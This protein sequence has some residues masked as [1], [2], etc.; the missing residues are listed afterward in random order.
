MSRSYPPTTAQLA[1][2]LTKAFARTPDGVIVYEA[3][4]DAAGQITDFTIVD[5]NPAGQITAGLPETIFFRGQ[6]LLTAYPTGQALFR[7]FVAV[8]ETGQPFRYDYQYGITGIWYQLTASQL[9]DGL[10]V[11]IR[12]ISAQ[13]NAEAELGRQHKLADAQARQLRATLDSSLNGIVALTAVRDETGRI[14]DFTLSMINAAFEQITATPAEKALGGSLLTLF[15]GNIET[16]F[17]DAYARVVTTGTTEQL[18]QHYDDG[19]LEAWF[20][21]CAVQSGPDGVVVTFMDVTQ[22]K[23]YEQRLKRSNQDLERF[24]F[25]ASHDLQEPLRKIQSFSD[26]LRNTHA[27]RLTDTGNDFLIRIQSAAAR[28]QLLIK[29]LLI[30]SRI[31]EQSAVLVPVSLDKIVREVLADL[32]MTITEKQATVRAEPLPVIPG[33]A[34]QLRQLFQNLLTNALKFNRPGVAPVVQIAARPA[35]PDD[36]PKELRGS[37]IVLTVSD[38]GIG[39]APEYREK[40]FQLFQRLH[41]RDQFA[42][43]GIGLSICQKVAENHGGQITATSQPDQGATFAVLL[44]IHNEQ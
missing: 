6:R 14:V 13:R 44:P 36:K 41:T 37:F 11:L 19:S 7:D 2:P 25:V 5:F 22:S 17:F 24:A 20:E 26:L 27:D 34:L 30:F 16:G 28:M 1:D 32:D 18:T 29:D 42:G 12:D 38:N 33:D 31:A 40:I 23:L 8:V 3:L 35:T 15:P 43:T 39:F 10:F 21:V 4:R 9:G